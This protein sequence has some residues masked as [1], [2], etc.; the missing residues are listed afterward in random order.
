MKKD[1]RVEQINI[2]DINLIIDGNSKGDSLLIEL[3][4]D[5]DMGYKYCFSF[6]ERLMGILINNISDNLKGGLRGV[7]K[8][9]EDKKTVP[10]FF[11]VAGAP[12]DLKF[13]AI[14]IGKIEQPIN[15][16]ITAENWLKIKDEKNTSLKKLMEDNV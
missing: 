16:E 9:I 15:F 6:S 13:I 1:V 4:P 11:F 7:I 12:G 3:T 2:K 8:T 5:N 10:L 14:F